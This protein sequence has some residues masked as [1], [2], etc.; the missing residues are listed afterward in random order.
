MG[1]VQR[2]KPR[3]RRILL[4]GTVAI[5]V[6]V[7]VAWVIAAYPWLAA[8]SRYEKAL[9]DAKDA[10][11]VVTEA[12]FMA[13]VGKADPEAARAARDLGAFIRGRSP[14]A[15]ATYD[16]A[17]QTHDAGTV[18]ETLAQHTPALVAAETVGGRSALFADRDFSNPLET[19]LPEY[20]DLKL[21]AKL[22]KL[23]SV[24]RANEGD[25]AGALQDIRMLDGLAKA[26]ATEPLLIAQMVS[27]SLSTTRLDAVNEIAGVFAAQPEKL[28]QLKTEAESTVIHADAEAA[29]AGESY[30]GLFVANHLNRRIAEQ[31]S[32]SPDRLLPKFMPLGLVR[33][34]FAAR[35]LE[36]FAQ[37]AR[38]KPGERWRTLSAARRAAAKSS[39]P[40][41]QILG[42]CLPIFEGVD[43]TILSS[44]TK[45]KI[46]DALLEIA[47]LRSATAK[48]PEQ[49][50]DVPGGAP[51]SPL[52]GEPLRFK[53]EGEKLTVYSI[54]LDGVDET[55]KAPLFPEKS[56]DVEYTW[57]AKSLP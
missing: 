38:S 19:T 24:V 2:G 32:V 28:A 48:W 4:A 52:G 45:A 26:V 37:A 36:N 16:R 20:S 9:S 6:G 55:E 1:T 56:D 8:A 7:G 27:S 12:D 10:G 35:L 14:E 49:W 3:G 51:V 30:F 15:K 44:A 47:R 29:I 39:E 53:V 11:V 43:V 41:D 23:R 50:S 31:S 22:L 42:D 21:G 46:L 13:M 18:R 40:T 54:G 33:R 34:A 17:V 5:F 57:I 25:F